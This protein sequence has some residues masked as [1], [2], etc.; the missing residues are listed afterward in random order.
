MFCCTPYNAGAASGKEDD[1]L[2][3]AHEQVAAKEGH[4]EAQGREDSQAKKGKA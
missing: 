1:S 2:H 3:Q 4:E